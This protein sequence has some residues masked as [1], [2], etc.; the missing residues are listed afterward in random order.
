MKKIISLFISLCI[1]GATIPMSVSA[2]LP[3]GQ[4]AIGDFVYRL[5][6]AKDSAVLTA[7]YDGRNLSGEIVIPSYV[8]NN[9]NTYPVIGLEGVFINKGAQTENITS[10]I[11]PDTMHTFTQANV[12]WGCQNLASIHLP[13]A[14]TN[15]G[16]EADTLV[17]AF[18]HCP[19]LTS[20]EI[21]AG[22]TKLK[23]TFLNSGVTTVTILG[24]SQV[25]FTS[26]WAD[27]TS[28]I[29]IYYPEDGVAPTGLSAYE[30]VTVQQLISETDPTVDGFEAGNFKFLAIEGTETVKILGFS[31]GADKN[32][33]IPETVTFREQT[34]TVVEIA[35]YAFKNETEI[36]NVELPETVSRIGIEAFANCTGLNSFEVPNGVT[37][38]DKTFIGCIS[39]NSVAIPDSVTTITDET[40][41]TDLISNG[42]T[43][44]PNLVIYCS[45]NSTAEE[46]AQTHNI[47]CGTLWDGTIDTSWYVSGQTEFSIS[48]P[49]QLAG[50]RELVNTGVDLFYGKTIKLEADINMDDTVWKVGIGCYTAAGSEEK[51]F[52]GVF[53]GNEHRIINF[54]YSSNA[55][56]DTSEDAFIPSNDSHLLHGLFGE[57]GPYGTVKN[58]ALENAKIDSGNKDEKVGIVVGGLIGRNKG[59]VEH[60]Y[61]NDIE[62]SGG[63]WGSF[64]SQSYGGLCGTST[65]SIEDCFVNEIDFTNVVAQYHSTQKSGIVPNSSG[66]IKNC[67]VSNLTYSN[68]QGYYQWDADGNGTSQCPIMFYY[69]PIVFSNT[70]TVENVYSDDTHTRNGWTT[71]ERTYEFNTMPD[72]MSALM[73]T[74]NFETIKNADVEIVVE[75]IDSEGRTNIVP[76]IELIFS[77]NIDAS[78]ITDDTVVLK[79][80]GTVINSIESV[81]S[82]MESFVIELADELL[83]QCEY[84]LTV[85]GVKDDWNRKVALKTITFKTADEICYDEFALYENYGETNERKINSL[86][87]VSGPVTAV[88]TGLK[89]NGDNSYN[90]VFSIGVTSNG[91]ILKGAA[92][93]VNLASNE[94]KTSP[95]VVGN[96]DISAITATDIEM[97]AVLCKAFGN[98]VPLIKSVQ[99][100]R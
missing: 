60:C 78:T 80:N 83:W 65:G 97:Q 64:N 26:A 66:K 43:P 75:A 95:V 5:N 49:A 39:L 34:Y 38:L 36:T 12:F 22:I 8:D 7:I 55:S 93:L 62:F 13:S 79:Y 90:A 58:L 63:Y 92:K 84:E 89:N 30:N 73:E 45:A 74:L 42:G 81:N 16:G 86:S 71:G 53:D 94:T 91:Q 96:I 88:I 20:V 37:E 29:T 50:L 72:S 82:G 77:R 2:A 14:L 56:E 17:G 27:G 25:D 61:I 87:N 40:F 6:G 69:D 1:L 51:N 48:T 52:N 59:K 100:S 46:Y 41:Y 54:T 68:A 28:G 10:I 33:S 98:V 70:G 18:R 11:L 31:D 67:Y 32:G 9:G 15:G 19:N 3:E 21:P 23:N 99:V 76:E 35:D 24:T 57:I 85:D 44:I 47:I 4:F